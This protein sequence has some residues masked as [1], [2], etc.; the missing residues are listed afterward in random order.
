MLT[1]GASKPF[2]TVDSSTGKRKPSPAGA[3]SSRPKKKLESVLWGK[4]CPTISGG[5]NCTFKAW[6]SQIIDL[7]S[8]YEFAAEILTGAIKEDHPSYDKAIDEDLFFIMRSIAL[9]RCLP[10]EVEAKFGKKGS[11]MYAIEKERSQRF[12]VN[13]HREALGRIRE[14][15]KDEESLIKGYRLLR[16]QLVHL[17]DKYGITYTEQEVDMF[18]DYIGEDLSEVAKAQILEKSG[19][20][21]LQQYYAAL[22]KKDEEN[23]EK[24]HLNLPQERP[25]K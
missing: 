16:L 8:P 18:M 1:I 17:S 15:T 2:R 23:G 7:I 3:V 14:G 13:G 24:F 19:C 9:D 25:D 11:K 6:N 5:V 12:W 22:V 20:S 21:T 10:L 4:A